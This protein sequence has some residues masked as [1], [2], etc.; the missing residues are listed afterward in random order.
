MFENNPDWFYIPSAKYRAYGQWAKV[1]GRT[2]EE[3]AETR[4][5]LEKEYGND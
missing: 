4:K 3:R 1:G 5:R 2:V